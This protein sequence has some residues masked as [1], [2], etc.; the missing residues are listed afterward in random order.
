MDTSVTD[1]RPTFSRITEGSKR[2]SWRAALPAVVVLVALIAL[3]AYLASSLSSYSQR[4]STAERDANQ[5]RDQV[6]AM[7]KQVGDLQKDLSLAHSPG[8]TTV[9]MEAA[10]P[11]KKGAAPASRSW[12]AAT[13]GEL[14]DG[15]SWMRV[16]AYGLSQNLDGGKAYHLWMVPQSGDPVDVGAIDIDQNGSGYAM[17]TELPGVDQGKSVM[18]TIDAQDAKQPGQTVAKAD[19]PKLQPTMIGPAP[20]AQTGQKPPAAEGQAKAGTETK[21]MHQGK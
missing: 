15:K 14:P 19:L 8:R 21:Q 13:W 11:G 10:Q 17:K 16:N 6:A 5:Y 1:T 2:H 7:T 9:I 18:L 12:A 3:I 20:Q 4:A